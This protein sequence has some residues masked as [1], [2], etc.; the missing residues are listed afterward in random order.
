MNKCLK[1]DTDDSCS[2]TER[3]LQRVHHDDDNNDDDDDDDHDDE[4]ENEEEMEE[5]GGILAMITSGS[6]LDQFNHS[7]R[8]IGAHQLDQQMEHVDHTIQYAKD[9]NDRCEE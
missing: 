8:H 7:P 3:Q 2:G 5:D 4:K 6:P 1:Q 9:H